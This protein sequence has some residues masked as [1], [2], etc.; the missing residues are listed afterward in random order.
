MRLRQ[1]HFMKEDMI[2]SQFEALEAPADAIT[3]DVAGTPEEIVR[4]IR[5][6]LRV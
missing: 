3:V 2:R 4:Q 6:D 1:G 5:T